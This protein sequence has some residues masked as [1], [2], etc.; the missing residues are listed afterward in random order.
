MK[1]QLIL[2]A[3]TCFS[4]QVFGQ[5]NTD[6][7]LVFRVRSEPTSVKVLPDV[8]EI[9]AKGGLAIGIHLL[10]GG[11]KIGKVTFLGGKIMG[12]DSTYTLIPGTG[13]EGILSVYEKTARG[14]RLILN[15]FYT[16]KKPRKV[17]SAPH[18]WS[19]LED[20]F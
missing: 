3:L 19:P 18:V 7:D 16:F 13:S 1:K 4:G 5:T 12:S 6:K 17:G 20:G 10:P 11:R 2:F 15:K 9:P 14:N 8:T